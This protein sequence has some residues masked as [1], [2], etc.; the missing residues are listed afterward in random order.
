MKK[1]VI[2]IILISFVIVSCNPSVT[3]FEKHESGLEYKIIEKDK[4]DIKVKQGDVLE[5]LFSYQKEDGTVLK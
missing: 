3:K 4:S 2:S 5:L 1:S